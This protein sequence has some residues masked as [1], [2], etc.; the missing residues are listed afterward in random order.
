MQNEDENAVGDDGGDGVFWNSLGGSGETQSQ[1]ERVQNGETSDQGGCDDG[2][3]GVGGKPSILQGEEELLSPDT[4]LELEGIGA[5]ENIGMAEQAESTYSKRKYSGSYQCNKKQRLDSYFFEQGE[6]VPPCEG[7]KI[8]Q[9][10]SGE[11]LERLGD[12]KSMEEAMSFGGRYTTEMLYLQ[13]NRNSETEHSTY[14]PP[15][16][17]FKG[18][19]REFEAPISFSKLINEGN[20]ILGEPLRDNNCIEYMQNRTIAPSILSSCL[21]EGVDSELMSDCGK[22]NLI[23]PRVISNFIPS[24]SDGFPGTNKSRK[25]VVPPSSSKA[26]I[27]SLVDRKLNYSKTKCTAIPNDT[28]DNNYTKDLPLANKLNKNN[29]HTLSKIDTS[30]T[31]H[32]SEHP[33]SEI[34]IINNDTFN[35]NLNLN[36]NSNRNIVNETSQDY[37]TDP[38]DTDHTVLS[39][40]DESRPVHKTRPKLSQ[41]LIYIHNLSRSSHSKVDETVAYLHYKLR[42]HEHMAVLTRIRNIL[43]NHQLNL[44]GIYNQLGIPEL[45]VPKRTN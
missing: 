14:L 28:I 37:I 44:I 41:K 32:T 38:S 29:Q 35:R 39:M 30:M 26:H 12:S 22:E 43:Q 23:D 8:S 21:S 5:G 16:D 25:P 18:K 13:Q 40:N 7:Y 31:H 15:G 24:F 11:Q 17:I 36:S 10:M 9:S 33:P 19:A 20:Y 3:I 45:L 2:E 6:L 42:S 1:T 34:D 4:V 27:G